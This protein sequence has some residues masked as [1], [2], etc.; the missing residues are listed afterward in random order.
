MPSKHLRFALILLGFFPAVAGG[1][2]T[3][4]ITRPHLDQTAGARSVSLHGRPSSARDWSA[5][6]GCRRTPSIFSATRLVLFSSL[7]I[8]PGSWKRVDAHYE[9]VLWTLPDR[10]RNDP[11]AKPLL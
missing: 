4:N 9:G 6:A 10:G 7:Q 2:E 1:E 11:A 5:P 8:A 3:L